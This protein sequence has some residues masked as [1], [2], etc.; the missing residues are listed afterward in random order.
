MDINSNAQLRMTLIFDASVGSQTSNQVLFLRRFSGGT[1]SAIT[2]P[3]MVRNGSA[4]AGMIMPVTEIIADH[5]GTPQLPHQLLIGPAPQPV[6]ATIQD[7]CAACHQW[8][9]SLRH[10]AGFRKIDEA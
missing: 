3:G 5:V 1:G 9:K 10:V 6:P 4:D 8:R 7:S 2:D